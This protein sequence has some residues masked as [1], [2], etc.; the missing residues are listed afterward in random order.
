MQFYTDTS[1]T[2]R[3]IKLTC[4]RT[5]GKYRV[6]VFKAVSWFTHGDQDTTDNLPSDYFYSG[7][8]ADQSGR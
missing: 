3:T 1:N 2:V 4:A 6:T 5:P 7:R 8:L